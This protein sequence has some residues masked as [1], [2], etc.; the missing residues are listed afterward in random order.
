MVPVDKL[1]A[2]VQKTAQEKLPDVKFDAAWKEHQREAGEEVFEIRGKTKSGKTRDI[3]VAASGKS[4]R[5]T[6]VDGHLAKIVVA[7]RF[8]L[9]ARRL[10]VLCDHRRA[11]G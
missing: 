9:L 5:W 10:H 4:W 8:G 2:S 1:P 11:D 6:N 3:K 7:G